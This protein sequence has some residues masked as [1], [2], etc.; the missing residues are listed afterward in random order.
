MKYN[1]KYYLQICILLLS[2]NSGDDMKRQYDQLTSDTISLCLNQMM[3]V[4]Y[5]GD[6][7]LQVK[8]NCMSNCTNKIV[9]FADT[10]LC[11]P[12]Y[13]KQMPNW[14]NLIDSVK[15]DYG[16]S[17][18]FCFVISVQKQNLDA[19]LKTFEQVNFDYP[20]F[21]DTSCV[22][23]RTNKNIPDNS[24]FHAFLLDESNN[25]VMV[26]NP[27]TNIK[28]RRLLLRY[29]KESEKLRGF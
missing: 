14:Y 29:L 11:T 16:N 18:E 9:V 13:I 27:Q 8:M 1:L 23:R 15:S 24:L 10:S 17:V 2:C 7:I 21:L 22:F 4:S 12:C 20:C 25:V 28:I 6:D 19:I 3:A 26:G 5:D